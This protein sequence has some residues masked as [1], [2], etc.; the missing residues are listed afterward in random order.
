MVCPAPAVPAVP[1]FWTPAHMSTQIAMSMVGAT[2]TCSKFVC[3]CSWG[4]IDQATYSQHSQDKTWKVIR[5]VMRGKRKKCCCPR[6]LKGKVRLPTRATQ[7][8]DNGGTIAQTWERG[9]LTEMLLFILQSVLSDSDR[10]HLHNLHLTR[11]DWREIRSVPT[12]IIFSFR[13]FFQ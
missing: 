10:Q 3:L 2:K 7:I 11:T 9:R 4:K 1:T 13:L 6:G 5:K 12:Q 8:Y